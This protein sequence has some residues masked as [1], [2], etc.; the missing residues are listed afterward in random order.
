[1]RVPVK[2][3]NASLALVLL[4]SA[5]GGGSPAA[6]TVS[7]T[8]PIRIAL[9]GIFS[10]SSY[11]PGSDNAF[12]LA[13]D[14]INAAGGVGGRQIEYKEFDTN[15]T[16][17][18][19]V[20]ATALALQYQPSAFVG[21]SISAGLKASIDAVNSANVPVIQTTLASLTSPK[22][23]G[24]DLTFRMYGATAQFAAAAD[25]Y[26]F[27]TLGVKR[28]MIVNT[29]DSAP[30]EGASYIQTDADKGGVTTMHRSVSPAVTD[31]TEP[32]LAA[33]AM[34][35][36][37]IWEWGYGTT[38]ALITK[39]A[40]AN[41]YTGNIMTFSA[42]SAARTGLIPTSLLTDKVNAVNPCAPYVLQTAEAKKFVAAYKAKYGTDVN[43]S[44]S[45]TWY[46]AVYLLKDAMLSA[47]SSDPKAIA[48]KLKTVDHKGICGEE[49][50]DAN[51]NLIHSIQ[52]LKYTNGVPVL[53]KDVQNIPSPF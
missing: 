40:A 7:G 29:A 23:L 6:P 12:K 2:L 18:G 41:G 51:H 46:D 52:I 11:V 38:D 5:C 53:V 50:A 13:V 30:T 47:G 9:M 1:M 45:A 42:G 49:K 27:D 10:G 32:V 48:A 22:S 34:N 28:M 25:G 24:S 44:V 39:T 36:Q 4:V 33:K 20:N 19:A 3:V 15:I 37:A 16:P 26:L 21:Y 8:G 35:A 14:E 31:L 17:Q 43:D